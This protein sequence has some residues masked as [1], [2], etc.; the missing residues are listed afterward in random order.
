M[1][2]LFFVFSAVR[3]KWLADLERKHLLE[4]ATR[5]G[6]T[7]LYTRRFF[8]LLLPQILSERADGSVTPYLG[9]IDIDYFKVVNDRFGHPAGDMVLKGVGRSIENAVRYRREEAAS[10][11]VARYGGEEIIVL[12]RR[13]ANDEIAAKI[14]ERI[15]TAIHKDIFSWNHQTIPV[16]VSIGVTGLKEGDTDESFIQRADQALYQAKQQGRNRI[17]LH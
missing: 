9:M 12:L 6:L 3:S 7:G 4:L 8:D 10:D 1:I 15:R 16:T 13:I 11:C 14:F 2:L 17:Y 5:D